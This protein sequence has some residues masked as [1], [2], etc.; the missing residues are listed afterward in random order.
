MFPAIRHGVKVWINAYSV[1]WDRL[2]L[3]AV[4]TFVGH[5][6]RLPTDRLAK[7]FL[8]G[9]VHSD[10]ARFGLRRFR[11][12]PDNGSL[13]K[14]VRWIRTKGLQLSAAQDRA[15][16]NRPQREWLQSWGHPC[17]EVQ[18]NVLVGTAEAHAWDDRCLQGIFHGGAAVHLYFV[19]GFY[20]LAWMRRPEGWCCKMLGC[21]FPDLSRILPVVVEVVP[22]H[23][24]HVS[25]FLSVDCFAIFDGLPC[26]SGA[27]AANMLILECIR[28]PLP[29]VAL[30]P[31]LG[32]EASE[33]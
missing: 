9:F 23:V 24:F 3:Q 29:W 12:G 17:P 7:Q 28:M 21:D 2:L 25:L 20:C 16:W 1:P 6:A 31:G 26:F 5:V 30:L 22:S 19:E 33:S 27:L 10:Q 11:T 14:V 8:D 13:R 15:E 4:F 18:P 32:S